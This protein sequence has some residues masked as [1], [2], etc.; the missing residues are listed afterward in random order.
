MKELAE[1]RPGLKNLKDSL[2]TTT[3]IQYKSLRVTWVAN[4][5]SLNGQ[6]PMTFVREWTPSSWQL[7]HE[8]YISSYIY[9][10]CVYLHVGGM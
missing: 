4:L 8:T 3:A 10:V 2:A 9:I 5:N 7:S 6:M 1:V